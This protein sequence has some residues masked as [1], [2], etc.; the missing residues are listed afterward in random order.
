MARPA[1]WLFLTSLTLVGAFSIPE[2]NLTVIDAPL[3]YGP[4]IPFATV[5]GPLINASANV[6]DIS[7]SIIACD[8]ILAP[9]ELQLLACLAPFGNQRP[10][11]IIASEALNTGASLVL[12]FDMFFIQSR[13]P[14]PVLV[15]LPIVSVYPTVYA[16]L[17]QNLSNLDL[18]I[19]IGSQ[20][21]NAWIDLSQSGWMIWFQVSICTACLIIM[22]IGGIK[23]WRLI[24]YDGIRLSTQQV[25]LWFALASAICRFFYVAIDPEGFRRLITPPEAGIVTN[26]VLMFSACSSLTYDVYWIETLTFVSLKISSWLSTKPGKAVLITTFSLWLLMITIG[27]I[28]DFNFAVQEIAFGAYYRLAFLIFM[29]IG[30]AFSALIA[31]PTGSVV[32]YHICKHGKDRKRTQ[33]IWNASFI[34]GKAVGVTLILA[35]IISTLTPIWGNPWS[36]TVSFWFAEVGHSIL[37]LFIVCSIRAINQPKSSRRTPTTNSGG[38]TSTR[39]TGRKTSLGGFDTKSLSIN[40]SSLTGN[41]SLTGNSLSA[42]SDRDNL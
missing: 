6:S 22:A 21:N 29:L 33:L 14:P 32:L 37:G 38:H 2:L 41:D 39:G 23:Q 31:W 27:G 10:L 3:Y 40:T 28:M 35:C 36:Q 34:L 11:G 26:L 24:Q 19:T 20:N 12:G 25:A 42:R 13:T 16:S 8:A 9:I 17:A 1:L 15:G 5:S 30:Y 7:G 18:S 4:I